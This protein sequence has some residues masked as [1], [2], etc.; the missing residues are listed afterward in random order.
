R[1]RH[2]RFSRDW[3]SDVCSSDLFQDARDRSWDLR[4]RRYFPRPP[5]GPLPERRFD[6]PAVFIDPTARDDAVWEQTW[7]DVAPGGLAWHEQIGRAAWRERVEHAV[8]G[9]G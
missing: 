4:S 9:G 3:S 7:S 8:V 6:G 5:A 1:R 2:T